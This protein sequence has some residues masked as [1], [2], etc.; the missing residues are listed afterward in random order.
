MIDFKADLRDATI[1]MLEKY[2]VKYKKSDNLHTLLIRRYTFEEKYI[3]PQKREVLISKELSES[4]SAC[5]QSVQAAFE[6]MVE[7]TRDGE[8]INCFQGR[9]L[10]GKGPRDYQNMIYGVLHLHLSASKNDVKPVIKKNGFAKPGQYLLFA[11]F[12]EAHAYFLK[13]LKHPQSFGEDGNIAIEWVSKDILSIIVHNW[14][15]RFADRKNDNV[16]LC[17]E[18]GNP[19]DLDDKAIAALTSGHVN[20]LFSLGGALY[21]AGLGMMQSGDSMG[22]AIAANK[23]VN[24]V[25]LAQMLYGKNEA[26]IC[27]IFD[28]LLKR[29]NQKIPAI[30]DIHYEYVEILKRFLIVDRNS[31][32]AYDCGN[33]DRYL[34][35]ENESS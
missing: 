21:R 15:E 25:E 26:K 6:K 13:I 14:P 11:H 34:L 27:K 16:T 20:T 35:F 4:L 24:D 7:W 8:D 29:H 3:K 5:P 32:A 12:D 9:G 19:I 1:E 10:Y 33:G 18:E 23:S 28:G 31:G 2:H 30:Y 17:D 22:A